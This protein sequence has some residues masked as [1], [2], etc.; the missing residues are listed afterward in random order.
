MFGN[1][2]IGLL[3]MARQARGMSQGELAKLA[4]L[5]QGHLSKIE[6]GLT[7]PSEDVLARLAEV[8]DFP[9]TLFEQSDNV[10]G[11]P[12]SVHGPMYRRKAS[13]G[14]KKLDRL[15]A[16]LNLR[17]LHL[18]RL[19]RSVDIEQELEF[20][21]F[22]IDAYGGDPEEIAQ[23]VRQTWMLPRGPVANL[24]R[25]V[26]RAG[27]L[28]LHCDFS[29]IS[30][31]GVTVRMHDFP[32]CIFLNQQQPADRQRFTLAHEIAHLVMHRVPSHTMEDEANTFASALLMPSRDVRAELTGR[33][34]LERL[35]SLKPVWRVSI[36]ALL[37]RAKT[38]GAITPN[39]SQYLW[40]QVSRLGLRHREPPE[41]NFPNEVPG[42]VP[43]ILRQHLQDLGY[44]IGDLCQVLHIHESELRCWYSMPSP[45]DGSAPH[46][47]V[48]K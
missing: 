2:N 43:E 39:Q 34:N 41:L 5:T 15:Q 44:T 26:E 21:N 35:A 47:R 17:I 28:V 32:P 23:L 10:F 12:V 7:D 1:L 45:A 9:V 6:N 3:Q 25:T 31:D 33:V 19:L 38:C 36:Q 18:K 46:L 11:L 37:Y 22:E 13:V 30:V 42:L 48:V 27:C 20:P 14:Q 40:K 4:D 8:L 16:E 24:I 29:G